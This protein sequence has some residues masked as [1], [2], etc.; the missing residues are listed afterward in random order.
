MAFLL[1]I[2]TRKGLFTARSDDR[3][4]WEVSGPH[5]LDAED[6]ANTAGVYAIG[7]DPRT[8]RILVGTESSHFG[9]SVWF[10]DD[11]GARWHEPARV[12][13][14][15]PS[16]VDAA[17]TRVWQFAFGPEPGTVYAGVEP[18]A[19]FRSTDGGESFTLVRP[20]WDHPHRVNWYPGAGGAAIHT[21]L[22]GRV[23]A[24]GTDPRAMT[25]AMSTGGVYQTEDGGESWTPA[26]R[27]IRA[28]F[29]PDEYPEYGQ[30]VHKV[31]VASDGA[32]Y[33]QNHHGVYR[34]TDPSAGW[35]SIADGLPADFGFAMVAHPRVPG[36]VLNFPV[37]SQTCHLPPDYLLRAFRTDDGGQT[38][39]SASEG[40]P[41]DPYYSIVLRD[42]A[43]T[44]GAEVPGFYFGTRA[45]DVFVSTDDGPRW[46]Q[47]ASHLPDV[48]C[49]RAVEV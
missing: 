25:V 49:V 6:Y 11:L 37:I 47:V 23:R 2:G 22:P 17:F 34:S 1:V 27:G 40:L 18:T 35:T 26:N 32:F 48:L 7:V 31:A 46:R 33:L 38:W 10:S 4:A 21:V 43:C 36:R 15:F 9:P 20:L 3:R 8:R 13:I 29:M 39:R 28:S 45:G 16:D 44:D 12:P 14:A 41:T 42:A 5:R 24:A 30:C 19:L